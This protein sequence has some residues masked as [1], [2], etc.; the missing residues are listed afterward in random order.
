MEWSDARLESKQ[1][2]IQAGD[3]KAK[4]NGQ[5]HGQPQINKFTYTLEIR[6]QDG[7][8]RGMATVKSTSLHTGWR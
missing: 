2:H 4:W 3:E 1:V 5:M 7:M 8:V 6:K